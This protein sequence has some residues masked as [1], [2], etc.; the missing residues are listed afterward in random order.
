M[1][2][3]VCVLILHAVAVSEV[4]PDTRGVAVAAS[5]SSMDGPA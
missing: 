2:F 3:A 4:P 1:Y 5:S